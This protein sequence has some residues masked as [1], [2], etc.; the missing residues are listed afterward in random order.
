MPH[1]ALDFLAGPHPDTAW[2][3]RNRLHLAGLK[4][5]KVKTISKNRQL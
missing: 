5:N 2:T 4:L 3:I 1:H